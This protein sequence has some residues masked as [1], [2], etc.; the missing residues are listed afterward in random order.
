MT[1]AGATRC[2]FSLVIQI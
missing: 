2:S 1:N